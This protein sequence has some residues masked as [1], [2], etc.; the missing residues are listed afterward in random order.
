[1][2]GHVHRAQ[3]GVLYAPELDGGYTW[4][5]GTQHECWEPNSHPLEKQL[6]FLTTEPSIQ[7]LSIVFKCHRSKVSD[8]LVNINFIVT[9]FG[10]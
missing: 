10:L 3:K 5:S 4:W 8:F 9:A 7:P 1:M 2:C 6:A